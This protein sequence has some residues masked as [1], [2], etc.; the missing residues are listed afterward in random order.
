ML[1]RLTGSAGKEGTNK[2]SRSLL[3]QSGRFQM[4]NLPGRS[5]MTV[6]L[7]RSTSTGDEMGRVLFAFHPGLQAW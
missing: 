7:I 5:D 6:R 2:L 1:E 3:L 4:L